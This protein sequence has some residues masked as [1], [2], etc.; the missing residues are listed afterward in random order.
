MRIVFVLFLALISFSVQ[1]QNE[2][3][4][5]GDTAPIFS[6]IDQFD[7]VISSASIL[8]SSDNYVLIFYR[9][10]WCK[11]CRKHLSALSD[12]LSLILE[13]NTSV[14]VVTPETPESRERMQSE[15]GANFS[16][17]SDTSY[18][19]MKAFGVDFVISDETVPR[20]RENVI[21]LTIKSNGNEE[22]ILPIPATYVVG[23]DGVIKWLHV[24]MDYTNRSTIK[25]VLDVL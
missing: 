15:T 9:G 1:A 2:A 22:G 18:A 11:Y 14:I 19:I 13:K 17:V 24:D 6:G 7:S 20:F 16:I 21:R 5:V 3:L 25:Q 8:D 10:F 23:K 4:Q 12:S